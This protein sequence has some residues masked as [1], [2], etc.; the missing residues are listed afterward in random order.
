[1]GE[2]A[3]AMTNDDDSLQSKQE[4]AL[5]AKRAAIF[6]GVDRDLYLHVGYFFAWYNNI[7]WKITNL[8][9]VIMGERDFSAFALLVRRMDARRKVRSLI[10]LCKVKNR[11]I[12]KPLLDRLRH[13]ERKICPLREKLAH[14]GLAR[15]EKK[16]RF[17]YI[18]I[19]RLP[20]KELGMKPPLKQQQPDG[21]DAIVLFQHGYWLNLFS[22]DLSSN[23]LHNRLI[24]NRP[25]GV[26]S[27]RSPPPATDDTP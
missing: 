7:D 16:P 14:H 18:R 21:I 3:L 23:E 2:G 26:K 17:L 12:E 10:E 13:F 22:E 25:L 4:K 27:P 15:D 5:D 19:D 20:W 24:E 11:E 8:M 9:A 6:S 1:L